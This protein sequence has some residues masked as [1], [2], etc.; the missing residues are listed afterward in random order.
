MATFMRYVAVAIGLASFGANA[1]AADAN[2]KE[3][4]ASCAESA[5]K[6][7]WE[8]AYGYCKEAA[9]YPDPTAKYYYAKSIYMTDRANSRQMLD[10]A[11]RIA[12]RAHEEGN[13]Q[14]LSLVGMLYQKGA[15]PDYQRSL[16]AFSQA[17]KEGDEESSVSIAMLYYDAHKLN[18]VPLAKKW[19]GVAADK[20]I[21]AGR[22]GLGLTLF[23]EGKKQ[24]AAEQFMKAAEGGN[25][26]AMIA[27][28]RLYLNGVVYEK[29][30]I[31]AIRWMKK[32]V[33]SGRK[34]MRSDLTA[35]LA[36]LTDAERLR[37]L[38][39]NDGT[40]EEG[41]VLAVVPQG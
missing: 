8:D 12:M 30:K 10:E 26:Q 14:A 5:E 37:L 16:D 31:E 36:S 18:N 2:K 32:A 24:E 7:A 33:F 28:A 17:Y 1:F 9:Y 11:L 27:V 22:Y 19:F 21:N 38:R 3:A 4:T 13:K 6:G 35:L 40:A 15:F 41:D 25:A 20:G 39:E 29:N 23:E 34:D